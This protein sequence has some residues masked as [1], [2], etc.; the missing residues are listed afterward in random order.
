MLGVVGGNVLNDLLGVT[1]KSQHRWL[2]E[3]Q[4]SNI[5]PISLILIKKTFLRSMLTIRGNTTIFNID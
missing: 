5:V 3:A 1:P 4:Q 2:L